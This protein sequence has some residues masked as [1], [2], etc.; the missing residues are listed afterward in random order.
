MSKKQCTQSQAKQF[1]PIG[2]KWPE[3]TSLYD[4]PEATPLAN[5]LVAQFQNIEMPG[6]GALVK[7]L[8]TGKLPDVP[9]LEDLPA[10]LLAILKTFELKIAVLEK[11]N[12]LLREY[13]SRLQGN[14]LE[15]SHSATPR[16]A[17]ITD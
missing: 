13:F 14:A 11:Q 5:A 12:A 4:D 16:G 1:P 2:Q 8:T 17:E 10:S 6:S 3:Y 9:G 15:N 7:A